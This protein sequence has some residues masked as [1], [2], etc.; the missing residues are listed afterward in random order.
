[1]TIFFYILLMI[2]ERNFPVNKQKR[3]KNMVVFFSEKIFLNIF[4]KCS[5]MYFFLAA[6]KQI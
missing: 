1:M 4:E 3:I 5:H 6:E 2:V